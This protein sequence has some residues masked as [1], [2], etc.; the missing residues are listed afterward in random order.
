MY[1]SVQA[2]GR[3]MSKVKWVTVDSAYS[4]GNSWSKRQLPT[5][6][7]SQLIKYKEDYIG[8]ARK[9]RQANSVDKQNFNQENS[10]EWQST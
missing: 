5:F 10:K 6:S 3:Q 7:G 1:T 8:L 4:L 9:K 2:T